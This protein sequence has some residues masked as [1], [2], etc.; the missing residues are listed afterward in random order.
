MP[1]KSHIVSFFPDGSIEH[2][3]SSDMDRVFG[4]SGEMR[5]VTDIGRRDE[6]YY[7]NWLLGP[8]AGREHTWGMAVSYG[9]VSTAIEPV[10]CTMHFRTYE[11]AVTHEVKMLNVMRCQ[12]VRFNG[13]TS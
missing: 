3:R 12:G 7:I 13:E 10:E 8:F 11:Q 9:V 4:H 6:G 5:R 1:N 2:T